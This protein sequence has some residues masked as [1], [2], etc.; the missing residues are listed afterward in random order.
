MGEIAN[1]EEAECSEAEQSSGDAVSHILV[2]LARQ[3]LCQHPVHSCIAEHPE[4]VRR[5][6]SFQGAAVYIFEIDAEGEPS[7]TYLSQGASNIFGLSPAQIIGPTGTQCVLNAIIEADKLKFRSTIEQSRSR[8][9]ERLWRGRIHAPVGADEAQEPAW[10]DGKC[11]KRVF[12]RLTPQRLSNGGVRFEGFMLDEGLDEQP[13]D[14]PGS[15]YCRAQ[16]EVWS[17]A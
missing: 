16:H 7:F 4:C 15:E 1:Q 17:F 11:C 8:M 5:F 2:W 12:V 14:I 13:V 3:S 9:N 10:L 6:D